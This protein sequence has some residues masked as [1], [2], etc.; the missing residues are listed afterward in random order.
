MKNT[1][2]LRAECIKDITTLFT[3]LAKNLISIYLDH[4]LSPDVTATMILI[5]FD[6]EKL[7]ELILTINDGHVMFETVETELLY[8]GK[9]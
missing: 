9:R 3:L 8:S 7:K 4:S 2:K 1:Y 5:D 6:I